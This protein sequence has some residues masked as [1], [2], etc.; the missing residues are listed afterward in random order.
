MIDQNLAKVL[1]FVFSPDAVSGCQR[2]PIDQARLNSDRAEQNVSLR[3]NSG[4][5]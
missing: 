3:I 4:H 1:L 2:G 5:Q